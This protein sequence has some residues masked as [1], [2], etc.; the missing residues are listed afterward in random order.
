MFSLIIISLLLG[1]TAGTII[2]GFISPIF[3]FQT[4]D[5]SIPGVGEILTSY[6]TFDLVEFILTTLFSF[7]F[8]ALN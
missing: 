2:A 3:P 7:A 8:F 1:T 4:I 6:K 5:P